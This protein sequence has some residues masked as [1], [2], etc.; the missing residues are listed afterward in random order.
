MF[1]EDST[2]GGSTRIAVTCL[3]L[4]VSYFFVTVGPEVM[5]RRP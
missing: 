4:E 5:E 1:L 2:T 3:L